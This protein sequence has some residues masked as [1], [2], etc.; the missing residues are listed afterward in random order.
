MRERIF[1]RYFVMVLHK[2]PLEETFQ[3]TALDTERKEQPYAAFDENP[4]GGTH[5]KAEGNSV[6]LSR[7]IVG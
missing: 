2:I 4:A 7:T 1:L 5:R 3:T 6:S